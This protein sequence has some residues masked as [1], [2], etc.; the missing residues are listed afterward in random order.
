MEIVLRNSWAV[1]AEYAV[2]SGSHLKN[3]TDEKECQP[4]QQQKKVMSPMNMWPS[5][6]NA[7]MNGR[8]HQISVCK[9][10]PR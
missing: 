10:A 7:G 2:I 3:M 6:A 4:R 5:Q 8:S 9:H 1:L